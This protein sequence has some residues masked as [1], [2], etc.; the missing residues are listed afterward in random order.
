MATYTIYNGHNLDEEIEGFW[1]LKADGVR[2]AGIEVESSDNVSDGSTFLK[3]RIPKREIKVD[4]AIK[5]KGDDAIAA[6]NA[7]QKI[8]D[9]DE[10]C[11][12]QT[13]K[14]PGIYLNAVCTNIE[15]DDDLRT[16]RNGTITFE[17]YDPFKHSTILKEFT[18]AENAD[19]ILEA[20]IVNSG[21][22]SVPIEYEITMNSDNGFI[23]IVSE[24]GAMQYGSLDEED[25]HTYTKSER[26]MTMDTVYNASDDAAGTACATSSK[27]AVNAAMSKKSIDGGYW[28]SPTL[29]KSSDFWNGAQRTI[30]IPADSE[31]NTGCVNFRLY[32][33]E[34]FRDSNS[35]EMGCQFVSVLD[36][37]NNVICA[38]QMYTPSFGSS[39]A[40][41]K[42]WVNNKVV[43]EETFRCDNSSHNCFNQ[44]NGN[45]CMCKQGDQVIIYFWGYHSFVVPEIATMAATKIQISMGG[46]KTA[47]ALS[48][49]CMGAFTFDKLHVDAYQDDPNRYGDGDVVRIDGNA[50]KVYVNGLA[51]MSDEV[52]GTQYFKAPPGETKVQFYNSSW[53]TENPTIKAYIREAY[54]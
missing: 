13:Y 6:Q 17:C 12:L 24:Y 40:R 9:T 34:W 50:A 18:A 52:R 20:S 16:V 46:Y 37:D 44:T 7:L 1:T 22:A 36:A 32:M 25:G 27:F 3:K 54:L 41:Y 49:N 11:E 5:A 15:L 28:L 26:L 2:F 33:K 21:S 38:I 10:P 45:N 31:G 43:E 8:L 30:T 4:F 14:E 51:R 53:V 47:T 35:N 23:G 42:M 19:G 48:R 29:K 39:T